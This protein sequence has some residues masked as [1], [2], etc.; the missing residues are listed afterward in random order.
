[1][2]RLNQTTLTRLIYVGEKTTGQG[3]SPGA[4]TFFGFTYQVGTQ[5][6]YVGNG[7]LNIHFDNGY[8]EQ[9]ESPLIVAQSVNGLTFRGNHLANSGNIGGVAQFSNS[10]SSTITATLQDNFV[11]GGSPAPAAF[12][13]CTGG[14]NNFAIDFLNNSANP[15]S[16]SMSTSDCAT[17]HIGSGAALLQPQGVTATVDA[18]SQVINLI[19]DPIRTAGKDAYPVCAIWRGRVV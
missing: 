18:S 11:Y 2:V 4:V 14:T 9:V 6:L 13:V 17:N 19:E 12:A 5:G 1:M 16:N 8:I 3:D 15:L 10:N 7:A